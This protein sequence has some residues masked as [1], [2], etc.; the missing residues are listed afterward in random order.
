[1]NNLKKLFVSISL[2]ILLAGTTLA[3]C[4]P[5]TPGE[6]NGPPCASTQQLTDDP[7]DQVTPSTTISNA[8]QVVVFD[9]VIDGL[10]NLLTVY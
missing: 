7:T 4:T 3:D 10:E 1:L 6:S 5:T 9:V 2:T 8:I